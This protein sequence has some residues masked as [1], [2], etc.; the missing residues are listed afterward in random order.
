MALFC[1]FCVVF[2]ALVK[3]ACPSVR[4][5]AGKAVLNHPSVDVLEAAIDEQC[6]ARDSPEERRAFQLLKQP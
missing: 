3:A 6:F 4:A 5:E 2:R 1:V